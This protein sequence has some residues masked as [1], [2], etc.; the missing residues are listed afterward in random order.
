LAFH[1]TSEHTLDAKNRLTVPAR[2]RGDLSEKVVLAMT[3]DRLPCVAVWRPRE[4]E[5]FT[6]AAIAQLPPLSSERNTLQRFLFSSA[7]PT[8]IDGAG[9]VGVP[10]FLMEHAGLD[11]EV[12]VLGA[13]DHLELWDPARWREHQ[14]TLMEG[15]AEITAH[16]GHPG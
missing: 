2:H 16:F 6:Q 7:H 3:L 1:G 15:V 13:D 4:Y 10:S 9:R 14:P 8:E 5:S 12:V 11:K